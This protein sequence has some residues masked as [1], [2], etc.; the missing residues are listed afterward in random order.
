MPDFR[1]LFFLAKVLTFCCRRRKSSE[2]QDLA[3][4]YQ[5]ENFQAHNRNDEASSGRSRRS[6]MPHYDMY[7]DIHGRDESGV[8]PAAAASAENKGETLK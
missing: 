3:Q 1:R 2:P 4:P 8:Y 6:G 7:E 5:I